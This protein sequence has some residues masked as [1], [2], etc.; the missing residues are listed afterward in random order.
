MDCLVYPYDFQYS[1]TQDNKYE[2]LFYETQLNDKEKYI[3]ENE[4]AKILRGV[5][6][7]VWYVERDN[8]WIASRNLEKLSFLY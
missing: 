1:H 5:F 2:Q 3:W 7:W 8:F 6:Y 4:L